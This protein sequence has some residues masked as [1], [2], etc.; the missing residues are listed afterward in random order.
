M[1]QILSSFLDRLTERLIALTAGLVSSRVAGMH[2]ASQAEQQSNLEDLARRYEAEGK[3][4]IA[5]ALRHR[6]LQISSPDL[7]SEAVDVLQ[8]VTAEP[9]RISGSTTSPTTGD[10][11]GLPDFAATPQRTKKSRRPVEGI[12]PVADMEA[13]S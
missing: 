9:A 10:L 11:K 1:P 7:A 3:T 6:L 13:G 5:N 2:A 8:R 12:P 4:E